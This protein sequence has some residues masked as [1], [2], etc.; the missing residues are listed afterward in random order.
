MFVE[1]GV[2]SYLP[3]EVPTSTRTTA[4]ISAY[5]H[6]YDNTTRIFPQSVR[7]CVFEVRDEL[8]SLYYKSLKYHPYMF[9]NCQS[10]CQQEYLAKLCNCTMDILYPIDENYRPCRLLDLPCLYKHNDILLNMESFGEQQYVTF[11]KEGINCPC[12]FNCKSLNYFPDV[13][14]DNLPD[15]PADQN[16]TE[17]LLEVYFLSNTFKVYRTTAVYTFVDLM[18]SFGGLAGLCIGCSLVG[19]TEI[20]FFFMCDIPKRTVSCS[21]LS[22]RVN[23]K[24]RNR[25]FHG[26][27]DGNGNCGSGRSGGGGGGYAGANTSDKNK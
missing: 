23:N 26:V 11:N 9:E 19:I 20:L 7:Q 22:R 15:V 24:R 8:Q 17:L 12:Y 27:Y 3:H 4:S 18:A 14:S 10:E 16:E 25:N 2:W 5:L 13:H 6:F 21:Q 1:P